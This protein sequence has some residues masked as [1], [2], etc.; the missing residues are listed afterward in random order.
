MKCACGEWLEVLSGKWGPYFR[1][2]NCGNITFKKGM[3][4]NKSRIKET[5]PETPKKQINAKPNYKPIKETKKE[6]T[7]TSDELDFYFT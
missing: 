7:I 4:M 6:I 5:K 1:C 2:I 3:E